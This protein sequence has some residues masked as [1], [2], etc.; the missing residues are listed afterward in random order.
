MVVEGTMVGFVRVVNCDG[1]VEG[2]GARRWRWGAHSE[3]CSG[4]AKAR[5]NRAVEKKLCAR[6][7][8]GKT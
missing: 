6:S 2:K 1:V 4:A 7:A 3:H 8:R 5:C